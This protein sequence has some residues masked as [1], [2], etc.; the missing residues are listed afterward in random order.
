MQ[1][2]SVALSA[3]GNTA[4]VGSFDINSGAAA[5][6]F[7]RSGGMWSQQGSKLVGTG[8]VSWL[9]PCQP[10]GSGSVALSADGNTAM[11]GGPE[12]NNCAGAAWVFTRSG[13]VWNQQG[14]KL[15]GTGAVG[16]VVGVEGSMQGYSVAMS[17]DGNTAMV[18][19]PYDNNTAGAA[20]VFTRSGGVWS[21]QGSKLVGTGAVG[22][23]AMQGDSVALSADGNT[24]IVGGY[25][26]NQ[27]EGAAWVFTRSG[28]VWSQQGSKLVGTG[29]GG[30]QGHSVALSADGNTAI[31]GGPFDNSHAGFGAAWL[32]TRSD[33][34]WSQ[35]GG[36]FF[37]TGAV[38]S[39]TV[40]GWSVALSGDGNTAIVGGPLDDGGVGAAWVFTALP[41]DNLPPATTATP[42]PGPNGNGWNNTN[43]TVNL[44]AT[45][46]P[47]GS[48]VKQIQIA[49][50][51]A[52]NTDLQTIAGDAASVT[53][54]A[55]GITLLRYFATDNAGN[56]ESEKTVTVQID[57]T[58]PAFSGLPAPGCA[59]WPPNHKL[60]QVATVTASD[61]LSGLLPGSFTATG[62]SNQ[63]ANGGIVITGGPNQFNIQLGADKDA[64]YTLVTTA[65]DLAG[66]ITTQQSTCSVPHDQGKKK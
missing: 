36:R 14:S 55:E 40:Q 11:V 16:E 64:I 28:G 29:A 46:Q 43:V 35:Q 62:T 54:S 56:Q 18:G 3:D 39:S 15:V 6:V 27:G 53:I 42:V 38:G 12:D 4:I 48:G 63:P 34:A 50:S 33:G 51:G 31:V 32:F 23:F 5:W 58:P 7:T 13:G 65:K 66:N 1:G 61:S 2:Q 9:Y 45:D 57:K 8:A 44:N 41:T 17:A 24:A 19:G 49:V 21:Q 59:I 26:E 30:Y 20:W 10:V 37:G 47:G 52:Q 60:V 25:N 22:P